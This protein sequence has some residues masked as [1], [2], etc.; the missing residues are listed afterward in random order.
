MFTCLLFSLPLGAQNLV[1]PGTGSNIPI[2]IAHRGASG[3]LPEHTLAAYSLAIWQGADF[4]EPDLVLTK[5]GHL[6]ARHDNVLN[7]TT[8]V[9]E[10]SEFS[11]R[12]KTKSVD[13]ITVEGWF[14]E[15][16]TLAEIKT[17]RAIERIPRL[18]QSNVK[19]NGQFRIPTLAEIIQLTLSLEAIIGRPIGIYPET[20]HPSY[21]DKLGLNMNERLI[22]VLEH[23]GYGNQGRV[24]IQ[25]FEVDNLK[26]LAAIT[27]IPLI[28]LMDVTGTPFDQREQENGLSYAD[29]STA[30][31]LADVA[32]YAAGV[33]VY[34]PMVL[35]YDD[36]AGSWGKPTPFMQNAKALGLLVH[37]YTFRAENFFLPTSLRSNPVPDS[38]GYVEQEIQ[39][40][41]DAGVDGFFIDHPDY[42]VRA[43]ATFHKKSVD[44]S[45]VRSD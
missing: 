27:S 23:Y 21:F 36:N 28:Q 30:K 26:R 19:F 4:I 29:M 18:R 16:F 35:E 14:S 45:S 22:D 25:S 42:G 39:Q 15:D 33:G 10:R 3:Y 13:G 6:I 44:E 40:F 17:L 12:K 24:F 1:G 2:V 38:Y 32:G 20:K 31:G 37:P 8:D 7:L 34:K 43:I 5:D 11:S 41:L 9:A